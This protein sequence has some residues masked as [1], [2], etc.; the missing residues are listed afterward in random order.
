MTSLHLKRNWSDV[1]LDHANSNGPHHIVR[2]RRSGRDAEVRLAD[3]NLIYV[4]DSVM[5]QEGIQFNEIS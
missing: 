3:D 4:A 2:R 1:S 5:V